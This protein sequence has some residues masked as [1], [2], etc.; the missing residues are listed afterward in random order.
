M[1]KNARDKNLT[2]PLTSYSWSLMRLNQ[3]RNGHLLPAAF[4]ASGGCLLFHS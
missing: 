1:S 3:R 2:S 4:S